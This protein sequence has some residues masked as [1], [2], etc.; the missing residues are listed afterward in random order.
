MK[1]KLVE[2]NRTIDKHVYAYTYDLKL[3]MACE[4]E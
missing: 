3:P 1:V 4:A 2:A